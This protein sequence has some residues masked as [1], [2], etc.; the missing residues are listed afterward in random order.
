MFDLKA[1]QIF[2]TVQP[3]LIFLRLQIVR[4]ATHQSLVLRCIQR[5]FFVKEE[6]AN[7]CARSSLHMSPTIALL[8]SAQLLGT[9]GKPRFGRFGVPGGWV[10]PET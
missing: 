6:R 10:V 8:R 7:T 2:I 1:L 9:C 4:S 3:L 5:C